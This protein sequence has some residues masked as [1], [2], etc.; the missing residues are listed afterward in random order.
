MCYAACISLICILITSHTSINLC[1]IMRS[2]STDRFKGIGI[3]KH[4]PCRKH[5]SVAHAIIP[6]DIQLYRRE[7]L[8]SHSNKIFIIKTKNIQSIPRLT[9][10]RYSIARLYHHPLLD[11][12]PLR[13][14]G[15]SPTYI[16]YIGPTP[17][18]VLTIIY[19]KA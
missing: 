5:I 15:I 7:Y 9:Y 6:R 12:L 10:R 18:A 4:I 3:N 2:I 19:I 13:F 17:I 1:N 8:F 11:A 16:L 14:K